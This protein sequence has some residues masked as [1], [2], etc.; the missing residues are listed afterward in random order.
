MLAANADRLATGVERAGRT[1]A[2][3]QRRPGIPHRRRL[4][5]SIGVRWVR[6]LT[7]RRRD[8]PRRGQG[9]PRHLAAAPVAREAVPV[10]A[11]PG[12]TSTAARCT[13]WPSPRPISTA[14]RR[15]L[16]QGAATSRSG[17]ARTGAWSVSRSRC[18]TCGVEAIPVFFPSVAI[19]GRHFGDGCIRNT[20]PLARRS[21][22]APTASSRSACAA[23]ASVDRATEPPAAADD[24]A[25]RRRAAR[26]GDAGRRAGRRRAQRAGQPS[27][28]AGPSPATA[29]NTSVRSTCCGS[30]VGR[31]VRSPPSSPR[32][33]RPSSAT[34][35]AAWAA[36]RRRPSCELP[37]LRRRV[38][39]ALIELGRADALA[40]QAEI[41]RFFTAPPASRVAHR[42]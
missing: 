41:E 13:R 6:D 37:A 30:A 12:R 40:A 5:R 15:A 28:C 9:A 1:V 17:H 35:C 18:R 14:R 27:V 29:A 23:P 32:M 34:C 22:S 2:R 31:S 3:A 7:L 38:L 16:R 21:S 24:R 10:G 33:C 25:G 11:H 20:T 42:G 8:R 39:P 36:T 26:C 4:A 19:G